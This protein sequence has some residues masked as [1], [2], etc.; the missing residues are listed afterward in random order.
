M[1]NFFAPFIARLD[2]AYRDRPDFVGLKARLLAGI[3]VLF[4]AFIPVNIGQVLWYPVPFASAVFAIMVAGH[5][6]FYQLILQPAG[7][8]SALQFS[9]DTLQRDG[10]IVMSLLFCLG[11][12][13]RQILESAQRHSEESLHETRLTN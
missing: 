1:P 2:S 9:A 10:L 3:T 12:T 11:I 8:A 6:G 7:L 13:L 4:L 5:V